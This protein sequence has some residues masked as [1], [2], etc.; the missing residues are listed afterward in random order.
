LKGIP[1][2]KKKIAELDLA[3]LH[4]LQNVEIPEITLQIPNLVQNAIVQVPIPRISSMLTAT[5][6]R[7]KVSVPQ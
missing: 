1:L 5:R 2:A 6:P 7:Q 4:L 3:L